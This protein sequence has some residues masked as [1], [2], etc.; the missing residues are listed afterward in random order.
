ME[1]R[2]FLKKTGQAAALA[3]VTGGVGYLF[4]NRQ[5]E[6]YAGVTTLKT[7][8]TV[9]DNVS[10]P[11]IA[12]VRHDDP[13]YALKSALDLVGG[14]GRF[15]HPGERVTIKPNVGWDR[16][17]AQAANTNPDLVAEMVRQC[18]KA[19]ADEVIVTDV[20]CNDPRRCFIRSGIRDAARQAGARVILPTPEDFVQVNLK[21]RVLSIWPVLKYF[22]QTD[23]LINMPLVKNHSLSRCTLGMKNLFGIL[24]GRRNQL[25]QQIDQSIVDL[26]RYARPT[27]T[28]V[29]ATRVL[30]RS[31]PQ[32]GSLD[33]VAIEN[34]VMCATDQV[35]ADA[36]AAEFLGLTG[37]HVGHITLAAA[38]GLGNIDYHAAGYKEIIS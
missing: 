21:G 23:R 17:P 3:A 8:F 38:A 35:A 34:S 19:G 7:D 11:R 22:V 12:L 33:D 25:H 6:T 10:L 26:A 37:V 2:E 14:I 15:I 29:D 27:L 4:H 20:S 36:R 16:T 28:V 9:A 18:L 13:T 24:G 5:L 1:R 32:G 30:F 31:G